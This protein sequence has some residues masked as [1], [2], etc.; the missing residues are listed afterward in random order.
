MI[1]KVS[2]I[3]ASI[4]KIMNS[5]SELFVNSWNNVVS[6]FTETIPAFISSVLEWFNEL[7]YRLGFLI[8]Q[9]IGYVMKFGIDL[10]NFATVTVPEFISQVITFFAELPEKMWTWLVEATTKLKQ[11]FCRYCDFRNYKNHRIYN[12]CY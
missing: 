5:I 8:G 12:K 2:E 11:F 4:G 7:P 10:W 6:F 1:S 9:A 3:G